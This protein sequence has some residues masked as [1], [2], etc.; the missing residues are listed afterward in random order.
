MLKGIVT[1]YSLYTKNIINIDS[2]QYEF[3]VNQL[4][5]KKVFILKYNINN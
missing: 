3:E 1:K 4:H 2:Q 5:I